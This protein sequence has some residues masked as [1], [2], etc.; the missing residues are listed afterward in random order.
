M[1]IFLLS[2]PIAI[3]LVG[4]WIWRD[5]G[6][7]IVGHGAAPLELERPLAPGATPSTERDQ[8]PVLPLESGGTLDDPPASE[9]K[10][11]VDELVAKAAP[12][13]EPGEYEQPLI[14]E[15]YR[16]GS[17]SFEAE[18]VK[19]VGGIWRLHGKWLSWYENG[20]LQERGQYENHLETGQWEWWHENGLRA[21]LG[22]FEAGKRIGDWTLYYEN[23]VKMADANYAEGVGEGPWILYYDD[24]SKWAQGNYIDGEIAGYWTIWDEFGEVNPERTGVYEAGDRVSP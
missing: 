10:A 8:L 18:Q 7:R 9:R 15:S 2:I 19:G 14:K 12:R 23:G 11:V 6:S 1:K 22:E 16:N 3:L 20:Q 21:A 4:Y 13:P 17:P 5:D 24:G